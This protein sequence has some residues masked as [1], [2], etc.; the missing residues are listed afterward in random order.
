MH[1][2]RILCADA[3]SI[4]VGLASVLVADADAA[5]RRPG[6]TVRPAVRVQSRRRQRDASR[7]L[8]PDQHAGRCPGLVDAVHVERSTGRGRP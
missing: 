1:E 3:R 6:R 4:V 2:L 8:R 5:S 7:H